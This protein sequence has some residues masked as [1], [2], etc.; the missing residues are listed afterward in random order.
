VKLCTQNLGQLVARVGRTRYDRGQLSVGIAHFGV[1][2]FHRSHQAMYLDRL[3]GQ[4]R[5]FD[6]A[7]CGVGVM[8][9]DEAMHDALSSQRQQPNP[10][11]AQALPE[12]TDDVV[13]DHGALSFG[14]GPGLRPGR[15]EL[16]V[17]G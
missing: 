1:G 17:E 8:P 4:G 15:G 14:W 11:R 9:A 10:D 6:W 7:V 2:G 16:G 5:A 12:S 13:T 3:M